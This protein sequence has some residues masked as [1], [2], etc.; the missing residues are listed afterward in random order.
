VLGLGRFG[1]RLAKQLTA[2]G[3][4]VL[5]CDTDRH[6]V[7]LI[8]DDIA[9]AVVLDVTDEHA[10]RNRG[11]HKVKAAVVAIGEHFEA[12]VLSTVILREMEV[13]RIIARARSRTTAQVLRRIGAHEVVLAEDEAADRWANRILGPSVLNQIEFHEGYSIVE[14]RAPDPWIG[15]GLAEL[16]VRQRFGV[17]VV[18]IKRPDQSVSSGVRILVLGPDQPLAEDDVLIVMGRDEQ[19]KSLGSV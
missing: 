2:A 12:S 9:Q 16:E 18:A 4:E 3:E 7:E 14:L 10:M 15:K 19:I 13:P 5:A 1:Q 17:H 6:A 8:A 11:V